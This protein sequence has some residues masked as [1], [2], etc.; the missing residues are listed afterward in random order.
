MT[1]KRKERG[2]Y[3]GSKQLGITKWTLLAQDGS[4]AATGNFIRHQ[5]LMTQ[6]ASPSM[7]V[8]D[9]IMTNQ[10][11]IEKDNFDCLG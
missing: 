5:A 1:A 10:M 4:E 9:E 2:I 6:T 11:I 7:D 8:D 3:E